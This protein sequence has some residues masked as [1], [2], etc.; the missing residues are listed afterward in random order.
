MST[1]DEHLGTCGT[2]ERNIVAV[3]VLRIPDVVWVWLSLPLR[4][5]LPPGLFL[6]FRLRWTDHL[7]RD[8]CQQSVLIVV[9]KRLQYP[10]I[11]SEEVEH[12]RFSLRVQENRLD[13]NRRVRRYNGLKL[14]ENALGV[15]EI[16]NYKPGHVRQCRYGLNRGLARRL[17]EIEQHGQ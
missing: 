13:R 12:F 4:S 7:L 11:H 10:R 2:G 9:Q 16:C 8:R 6:R 15:G 5:S 1:H 14:L 17:L 3:P